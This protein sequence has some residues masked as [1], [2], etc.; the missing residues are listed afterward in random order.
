[1]TPQDEQLKKEQI[2]LMQSHLDQLG[3]HFDT[4]QIF[5][6]KHEPETANGTINIKYGSG[7]IFA[8]IG[9]CADWIEQQRQYTRTDADI[10]QRK[11]SDL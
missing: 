2:A 4:V 8:R 9:Q 3:E 5:C 11:D 1:M 10:E 7:N 6:T